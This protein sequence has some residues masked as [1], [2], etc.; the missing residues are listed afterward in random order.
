MA[1]A[2]SDKRGARV[3]SKTV[4]VVAGGLFCASMASHAEQ[5]VQTKAYDY[6]ASTGLLIK[7]II[8]PASSKLCL[9]TEYQYDG[10]GNK[11]E[12]TQRNC[13]GSAAQFPQSSVVEAP[14]PST[15]PAPGTATGAITARTARDQYTYNTDGSVTMVSTSAASTLAL[16]LEQTR[17]YGGAFGSL[18]SE[19]GPNV[20]RDAGGAVVYSEW[21]YDGFGRKVVEKLPNGNGTLI[22]YEQCGGSVSCPA[23]PGQYG[24]VPTYV[25][26]S[27][28]VRGPINLAARTGG[29]PNGPYTKTYYDTLDRVVRVETQGSD[30]SGSAL[31]V[32]VDTTYDPLGRVY[33]K[34]LPY[35]A[36]TPGV[37]AGTTFDYDKSGRVILAVAADSGRTTTVHDGLRTSVT[38]ARSQSTQKWRNV[39]GQVVRVR[40]HYGKDLTFV[41]DPVGNLRT[42]TDVAGNVVTM[43][44]DA[45]GRKRG[46]VDPDMGPWT[47]DYDAI[48]NLKVQTDAKAQVTEMDY[49]V[50]NRLVAKRQPALNATW[51][52]DN[53]PQGKG[54]LCQTSA[55]AQYAY[56]KT[57]QYDRLSRVVAESV[58]LGS[59]TYSSGVEYDDN[60]TY[61]GK[62][63]VV[64]Y[65]TNMRVR[66]IYTNLGFLKQVVNDGSLASYWRADAA[67]AWGHIT[68]QT[69]GNA[70]SSANTYWP[71]TGR[72]RATTAVS[73]GGTAIQNVEYGYDTVGNLRT[74]NDAIALVNASYDYDE[75]NR[76]RTETRSGGGLPSAQ[77]ITWDYHDIGT[78]RSRSDVGTY[79]YNPSGTNSVRPHAVS[80]ITGTVNGE[81]NPS[82]AYDANGNLSAVVAA[83]GSRTVSWTSFNKVADVTR[84]VG[85]NV[86]RL[87]YHYDTDLERIREVYLRNG[88]EQRTTHYLNP[89]E[90]SGLFYEEESGV[91]GVKKKHYITAGDQTVGL[92]VLNASNVQ[93][94]IYYWHKDHLKSLMV[95]T[96]AN[97][98]ASERLAYEPFGKR[99]HAN[100]LTDAGGTLTSATTDRGFTEH[101]Q[102]DEVG[103]VNMNGRIYDA[104]VSRFLSPDPYVQAPY[105]MQSYDRFA[106]TFNNPLKYFDPTGYNSVSDYY[107]TNGSSDG[108]RNSASAYSSSSSI[109][110]YSSAGVETWVKGYLYSGN[111]L[112]TVTHTY[113]GS[114]C[115]VC[116]PEEAGSTGAYKRSS[117]W[118]DLSRCAGSGCS[119][120]DRVGRSDPSETAGE[121]IGTLLNTYKWDLPSLVPFVGGF[122]DYGRSAVRGDAAGMMFA[123]GTI[124]LDIATL[125]A[126]GSLVRA[127]MA[128]AR[129]AKGSASAL[130]KV[131][132]RNGGEIVEG[133]AQFATR[134][135]ARQ[136][137]SEMAG[138]LGSDV[139]AIRMREFKQ[140]NVPWGLKDSNKVIGRQSADGL[141]GWRD[142]FLGHPQ[143]QMGPHVNVWTNG[144]GFHFFY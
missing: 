49:D 131:V 90:G 57:L 133:G 44:Y 17:V 11:R 18:L 128:A 97:G 96:D 10:V 105:F 137:A 63:R 87:E 23:V 80:G 86:N 91:A 67:D 119:V 101:E 107:F 41:Y 136:A 25:V 42:T 68:Q 116:R 108:G 77:T 125:G 127:E 20:L 92:V 47:Y 4:L 83:G 74:R 43:E 30:V 56:S 51:V 26:T 93:T 85:G 9:V 138:N 59:T 46:M 139:Q 15:T 2:G 135:Q 112:G 143:F 31:I 38:N 70:V 99:R 69:F 29:A 28:P 113:L 140:A 8:E 6:S 37:P 76:L 22:R 12:V 48:G 104:A 122:W 88:V 117:F 1:F 118:S 65:P 141:S 3:V 126:E 84:N 55:V 62:V 54:Q 98:A 13:N 27:T 75:L 94:G 50:L 79:S 72:L 60:T 123:A 71:L 115:L 19:Q 78:I 53:C 106:Y 32:Y 58:T 52:Y 129:A 110:L 40:D 95:V 130:E 35:L 120:L 64:R 14:A 111:T 21:A 7:E 121:K 66:N 109:S 33:S 34:S 82:Y 24:V 102:M 142:D 61:T 36:G 39:I 5:V 114:D 100:G 134:R 16:P 132:A 45:R 103:L 89:A 144:S 81:G 73:S 124:G